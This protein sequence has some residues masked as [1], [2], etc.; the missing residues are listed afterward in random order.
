[1]SCAKMAEVLEMPFGLRTVEGPRNLQTG[2]SKE[3][4]IKWGFISPM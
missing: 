4:Y 3:S 2:G 1:M